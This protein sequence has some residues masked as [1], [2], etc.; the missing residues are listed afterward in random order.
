MT[1]NQGFRQIVALRLSLAESMSHQ[2]FLEGCLIIVFK[3]V[4]KLWQ[5]RSCTFKRAIATKKLP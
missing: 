3:E 1:E 2:K 4:S 5:T